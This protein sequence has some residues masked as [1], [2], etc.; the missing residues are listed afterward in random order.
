MHAMKH[1]RIEML[2][3][4]MII[5]MA[6][7]W[8][9]APMCSFAKPD[10]Y[11]TITQRLNELSDN[12][13]AQ[14][15]KLGSS[16]SGRP[17]YTMILTHP[18][19]DKE[20]A[21]RQ[22]VLFICGQHGDEH[23][24]TMSMLD[25]AAETIKKDKVGDTDLSKIVLAIVPVANP[26]G[27]VRESR[28][29]AN[30]VDLNRDWK[31]IG[32]PETKCLWKFIS[33]FGPSII[34]DAHE[35]TQEASNWPNWVEVSGAG[36]ERVLKLSR[37]I[38]RS[39]VQQVASTGLSLEYVNDHATCDSRLAHR[40]FAEN[41]IVS[42]L[43]ETSPNY[44][45]NKRIQI[46]RRFAGALIDAAAVP[47]NQIVADGLLAM[48]ESRPHPYE[49]AISFSP[50]IHKRKP[51]NC[52]PILAAICWLVL[53]CTVG[54]C[55]ITAG[56]SD[57]Y[58]DARRWHGKRLSIHDAVQLNVSTGAKLSLLKTHRPRTMKRK[59]YSIPMAL[60]DIRENV[61]A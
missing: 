50:S 49:V 59:K 4:L 21:K 34:L 22:R 42:M 58:Q 6:C 16:V 54:R 30:G 24:S 8:L 23:T 38:G 48:H 5:L 60:L 39:A 41:G 15:V 44:P 40:A 46:Y 29:N 13:C 35:W 25:F 12:K 17:I 7:A 52:Y 28:E 43:L 10:S 14:L 3:S 20:I 1:N 31:K 36:S 51:L 9:A 26:D 57:T 2:S 53:I 18:G 11:A 55:R 27:F 56:S 61:S 45:Y 33:E 19:S 37:I 32:Q 47:E